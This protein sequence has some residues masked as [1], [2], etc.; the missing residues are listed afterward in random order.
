MLVHPPLPHRWIPQHTTFKSPFLTARFFSESEDLR[1]RERVI[2]CNGAINIMQNIHT[3]YLACIELHERVMSACDNFSWR[4][5]EGSQ[6]SLI[7]T[8]R[9]ALH[10]ALFF[11]KGLN[12]RLCQ[13]SIAR[14]T[15]GMKGRLGRPCFDSISTCRGI[16]RIPVCSLSPACK[17][18]PLIW[19]RVTIFTGVRPGSS[20]PSPAPPLPPLFPELL[21]N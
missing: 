12:D 2:N 18:G 7:H 3:R 15:L 5:W 10:A 13:D 8:F 19:A 6:I 11:W 4:S 9:Y 14:V 1:E 20:G 17:T 16:E 21:V